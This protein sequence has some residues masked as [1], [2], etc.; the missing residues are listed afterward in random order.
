MNFDYYINEPLQHSDL[1]KPHNAKNDSLPVE[2]VRAAVYAGTQAPINGV[3]QLVDKVSGSNILPHIQFIDPCQKAEFGSLHW[4]TQQFGSMLGVSLNMV[5]L[6]KA[7]GGMSNL[8]AGKIENTAA[9]QGALAFRTIIDSAG[10]GLIHN[11]LFRQVSDDEGN[12]YAARGKNALIGAGTFAT[13]TA[14]TLG[15]KY[16]GKMQDNMLGTVLRSDVGSTVLSGIPGGFAYAEM[17]S[18][19]D[20]KGPADIKSIGQSIYSFSVLGGAWAAGKGVLGGSHS[21][22]SLN[23]QLHRASIQARARMFNLDIQTPIGQRS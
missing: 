23:E 15:I 1:L 21:E 19:A 22:N 16:L 5:Y 20:G 3:V 8:L 14:S 4:H 12:F 17:K 18:L 11:G 10:T 9:N 13:A 6:N 2:F 7:V